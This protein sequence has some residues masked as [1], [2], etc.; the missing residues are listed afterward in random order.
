MKNK[1]D[2]DSLVLI[3]YIE[4]QKTVIQELI[5]KNNELVAIVQTCK[6]QEKII[7]D[8]IDKNIQMTSHLQIA[9]HQIK[10]L[11]SINNVTAKPAKRL[12]PF[13]KER[14]NKEK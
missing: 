4:N 13:K 1:E 7:N 11:E 8:L 3:Q 9:E 5:K 10:H 6:N 14:A 12:S 2:L